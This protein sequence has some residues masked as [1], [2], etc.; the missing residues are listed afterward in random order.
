MVICK[1]YG[2]TYMILRV[3]KLGYEIVKVCHLQVV[4]GLSCG[5]AWGLVALTA[6]H[7]QGCNCSDLMK[8][9]KINISVF[10]STVKRK[11]S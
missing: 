5:L 9:N 11:W 3:K 4:K 8:C 6:L 7:W 2:K 10:C 1:L